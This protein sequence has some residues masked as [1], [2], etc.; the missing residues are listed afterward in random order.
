MEQPVPS[1]LIALAVGDLAFRELG[2]R[3]GVYAE[4]S[5]VDAAAANSPI[6]KP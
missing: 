3:S 1:Y 6:P 4:P 5:L 2:P